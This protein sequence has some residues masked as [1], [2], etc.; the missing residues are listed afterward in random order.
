MPGKKLSIKKEMKQPKNEVRNSD[1]DLTKCMHLLLDAKP[2]PII[3]TTVMTY[4]DSQSRIRFS[5]ANLS[6]TNYMYS[7]SPAWLAGVTKAE[8]AA[9]SNARTT[10]TRTMVNDVFDFLPK[11]FWIRTDTTSSLASVRHLQGRITTKSH[12]TH[13]AIFGGLK[14]RS[15]RVVL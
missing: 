3:A 7:Y 13:A 9:M 10:R 5:H 15:L 2:A 4:Q 6:V 1:V 14:L 8:A 12:V 11:W